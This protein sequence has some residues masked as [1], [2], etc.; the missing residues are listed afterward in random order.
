MKTSLR[1]YATTLLCVF[2]FCASLPADDA[3]SI[4]IMHSG[5][6]RLKEDIKFI[7]GLTTKE[8]QKQWPVVEGYLDDV[9]LLGIDGSRP[10]RIDMNSVDGTTQTRSSF[11]VADFE[12]F[13]ENLELF[14]IDL[15]RKT[16]TYYELSNAYEGYMRLIEDYA[17]IAPIRELVPARSFEPLDDSNV[18][19]YFL[20]KDK[21]L[22]VPGFAILL[23]NEN[24]KPADRRKNFGELKKELMAGVSQG[25]EETKEDFELRT[26]MTELQIDEL[27]RYYADPKEV[28]IGGTID[29]QAKVGKMSLDLLPDKGT[30]LATAVA[31]VGTKASYF[32]GQKVPENQILASRINLPLDQ[33]QQTN[34]SKVIQLQ[35]DRGIASVEANNESTD[36]QKAALKKAMSL[37][38]DAIDTTLK[39]N[40][41]DFF[42]HCQP[43]ASGKHT[44]LGGLKMSKSANL[45]ELFKLMP[46]FPEARKVTLDVEKEGDVAIH[47][48]EFSPRAKPAMDDFFGVD[49][50]LVGVGPEAAWFAFGENAMADLKAAIAANTTAAQSAPSPEF[51]SL[52]IK[53]APFIGWQDR[54]DKKDPAAAKKTIKQVSGTSEE[55]KPD[56]KAQLSNLPIRDLALEA[57]ANGDDVL[58]MSLRKEGDRIKGDLNADTGIL[59]FFGKVLASF[60][61]ENLEE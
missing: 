55:E 54:Q 12:L 1:M 33:A 40:G 27:A 52:S 22:L 15:K 23:L 13:K 20:G 51:F 36:E 34:A 7:F 31:V 57:F 14:G 53:G 29:H 2:G 44:I 45:T 11:P 9:F 39:E 35:L 5:S 18:K 24:G 3:P 32:A 50:I 19:K 48:F 56:A 58:K 10:L 42:V 47:E 59:R 49:K 43:N 26:A 30:D 6:N 21:N 4:T 25:E 37:A 8:E 46:G 28:L 60:S 61:K 41:L 17:V 16:K 38:S